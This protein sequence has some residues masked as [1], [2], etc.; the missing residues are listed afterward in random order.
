[1]RKYLLLCVLTIFAASTFSQEPSKEKKSKSSRTRWDVLK[2]LSSLGFEVSQPT[3]IDNLKGIGYMYGPR[4]QIMGIGEGGYN[5]GKAIT[6]DNKIYTSSRQFYLGFQYPFLVTKW[7]FVNLAPII[8]FRFVANECRDP[9]YRSE[10]G[11]NEAGFGVTVPLGLMVKLGPINLMAKYNFQAIYNFSK[12][13]GLKGVTSYPSLSV[14]FSPMN[15]LMNPQSF[16]HSGTK[17]TITDY[18]K[19]LAGY[20]ATYTTAGTYYQAV[21]DESWTETYSNHTERAT[22]V[23]PFFFIGPRATTNLMSFNKNKVISALG[24]NIGFRRGI[25]FLNGYFEKGDV[26]FKET[27]KRLEDSSYLKN[28]SNPYPSQRLDGAFVNST[29]YG[30]Q[31][32]IELI[33]NGL[34]KKFIYKSDRKQMKK[35][36][37]HFYCVVYGGYGVANLGNIK[38]N[39]DS[40]HVAYNAYLDS[41]SPTER[42]SLSKNIYL[43]SK[44]LQYAQA[45]IQIGI[46]AIAFNADY[47]LYLN[48]PAKLSGINVGMSMNIPIIRCGRAVKT[49]FVMKRAK[50]SAKQF[51]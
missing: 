37:S 42:N 50:K 40:G 45:G 22:D 49:M 8:G 6:K 27:F 35:V 18:Q 15:V 44:Q 1:M 11:T 26:N 46:G 2:E 43:V 48:A 41:L 19:K 31:I 21:Y 20:K 13:A 25:W 30:G 36:T 34:G 38:F 28:N 24:A 12:G 32:G 16:T 3:Y 9:Y 17:V 10:D 14:C 47:N 33:T 23:Q 5:F 7:K 29:R 51:L 4:F 39:T